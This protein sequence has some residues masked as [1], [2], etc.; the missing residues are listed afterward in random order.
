M[1]ANVSFYIPAYNAEKT[2]EKSIQS[3]L[4]QTLKAK[5]I[6]IIDDNSYDKTSEI[7]SR[8]NQ[9]KLIKNQTN[10]GLGHNRNLAISESKYDIVASIDADVELEKDW[11]SILLKN[12]N[13]NNIIMCGGQMIEKYVQLPTNAWRAKYYSQNWGKKDVINPQFLFGCNTVLNK[14]YWEKVNGYDEKLKTNGEDINFSNKLKSISN[15]KLF[16]SSGAKCYHLQN[17]T[18]ETLSDR[19]WRYH[20]YGYKIKKP[21]V[22][23]LIKLTIKQFRFLIIRIFENLIKKNLNFIYISFIIFIKFIKN[24]VINLLKNK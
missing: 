20:S 11:L 22:L 19:I 24:E 7:I 10:L 6:I 12:L 2:I 5:E 14:K 15:I 16:Y 18:L 1:S 23:K 9:I 13:Q 21:S 3:V 4:N 8:Y 17:D